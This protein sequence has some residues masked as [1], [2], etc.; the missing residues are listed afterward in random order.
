[1]SPL[2][3]PAHPKDSKMPN[4]PQAGSS[5]L[6]RSSL[7]PLLIQSK[8]LGALSWYPGVGSFKG[9]KDEQ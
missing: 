9:G 3:S 4:N 8:V 6:I 1:M 5:P 7:W 2:G